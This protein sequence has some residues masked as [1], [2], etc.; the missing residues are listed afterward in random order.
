MKPKLKKPASVLPPPPREAFAEEA[1]YQRLLPAL[2]PIARRSGGAALIDRHNNRI[3]SRTGFL[4][5]HEG[6]QPQALKARGRP[7]TLW[8]RI[9]TKFQLNCGLV[10]SLRLVVSSLWADFF[11]AEDGSRIKANSRVARRMRSASRSPV[12]Q[13]YNPLTSFDPV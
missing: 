13:N 9:T 10:I 4:S 6:M 3:C 1:Y 12:A 11:G 8:R 7:G 5:V 2:G